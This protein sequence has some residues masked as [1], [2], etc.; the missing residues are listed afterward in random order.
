MLFP[1]ID[2]SYFDYLNDIIV[3]KD[4]IRTIIVTL[5]CKDYY[6]NIDYANYF[7]QFSTGY[8]LELVL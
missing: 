4:T 3:Q 6:F 7:M 2:Y 1:Y 8:H 5:D